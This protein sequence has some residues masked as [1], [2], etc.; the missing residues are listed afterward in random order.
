MGDLAVSNAAEMA[1]LNAIL[2]LNDA[3][4]GGGDR[5]PSNRLPELK[6]NY[7]R[8]DKE[9]RSI[10]DKI[11][12]FYVKGLEKEVYAEEVKIRVLSQ[13]FQWIDFDE[14]EMKPRNRTIMIPRF[15]ME[16][17]DEL[18]TIRCGKPTSK[19][20]ADWGKEEKAK[21]STINLFRQLRGLVSYKGVTAE[22][23]EV[24]IENQPMILM[25]KRGNYMTFEDQVIKKIS[26]R[27]F[28]DFWVTVK[29]IEQE[30]GSVVYYTFD[31][32]PDLL[33]PVP[34]DDNTYQTMLRFAEMISSDNDKIK[35]K[36]NA[37]LGGIDAID[38]EA[39]NALDADLED[40]HV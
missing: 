27:D 23:E 10:K 28:K 18:G 1:K 38:M 16:P 12:M 34:L 37:A 31:Y 40:D 11:G 36:Y 3:P 13:V 24:V 4:I 32:E 26:G 7:Q 19:Q 22:G 17:I 21:F 9:G 14:E 20:M 8:K 5:A 2:G 25:N 6:I 39:M 29:S 15:S 35:Q 30:M 33:N